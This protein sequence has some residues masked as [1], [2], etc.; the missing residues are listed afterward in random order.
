[1]STFSSRFV[2][3]APGDWNNIQTGIYGTACYDRDNNLW[4]ATEGYGLLN[5]DISTG[6]THFYL[7]DSSAYSVYNANVIKSVFAEKDLS[8]RH[9]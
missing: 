8:L 7:I 3:H 5:Y 9:I 4:V 1:M 2:R 6:E